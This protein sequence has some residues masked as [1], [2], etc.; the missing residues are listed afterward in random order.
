MVTPKYFTFVFHCMS[1]YALLFTA[2]MKRF[3]FTNNSSIFSSA[4]CV[5]IRKY[6]G[7]LLKEVSSAYCQYCSFLFSNVRCE[8]CAAPTR[9]LKG[10]PLRWHCSK[11]QTYIS[12]TNK[13][14]SPEISVICCAPIN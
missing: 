12:L 10:L 5:A 6:L 13:H 3:H 7:L 9:F 1:V 4:S 2:L 11:A 8:Y 14:R